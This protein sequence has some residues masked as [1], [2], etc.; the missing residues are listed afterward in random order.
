MDEANGQ[1]DVVP[2]VTGSITGTVVLFIVIVIVIIVIVFW[3]IGRSK[4]KFTYLYHMEYGLLMTLFECAFIIAL[5]I[6]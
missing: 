2:I 5:L 1:S 6:L 4:W 3:K